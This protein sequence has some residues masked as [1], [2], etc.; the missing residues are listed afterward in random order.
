MY[1]GKQMSSQ[2]NEAN[3]NNSEQYNKVRVFRIII[4]CTMWKIYNVS[5]SIIVFTMVLS[6]VKFN[7]C[8][9]I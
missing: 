8:F 6:A 7:V 9:M 1:L 5:C 2:D 4:L 3:T